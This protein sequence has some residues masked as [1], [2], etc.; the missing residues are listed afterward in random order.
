MQERLLQ[1]NTSSENTVLGVRR[2]DMGF[3]ANTIDFSKMRILRLST[4]FA[5]PGYDRAFMEAEW[6]LSEA[7]QKV[8]AQAAWAVYEVTAGL[9]GPAFIIVTPM[10]LAEGSRRPVTGRPRRCKKRK[11]EPS[12]STCRNWRE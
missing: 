7:S 5:H 1:E 3:R 4:I 2:D 6:S 10:Q 9:P 8:N 11:A 12:N